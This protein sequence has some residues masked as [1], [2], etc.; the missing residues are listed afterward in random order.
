MRSVPI[1]LVRFRLGIGPIVV[2]LALVHA[3]G[4]YL[5]A[6]MVAATLSDTFDGVIARRLGIATEKLRVADSRADSVYNFSTLFAVLCTNP[7][8]IASNWIRLG[9]VGSMEAATTLIDLK[10]YGRPCSHHAYSAKAWAASYCVFAVALL[11][12]GRSQPYASICIALGVVNNLEGYIMRAI[13]PGWAHD[14]SGIPA[15]LRVR[16]AQIAARSLEHAAD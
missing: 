3:A 14:V 7:Q 6:C 1:L 11:G 2:V 13:M 10:R 12:F 15:A 9:V 8:V 5:A 4:V 16:R